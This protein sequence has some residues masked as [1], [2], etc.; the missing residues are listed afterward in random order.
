MATANTI[1]DFEYHFYA[2]SIGQWR[3]STDL[4]KL[5]K[6]MQADRLPY[7]LW[8]VPLAEDTPYEIQRYAPQV[9]GATFLGNYN[10]KGE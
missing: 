5:I 3:T 10:F 2:S 9:D 1:V 4:P 7:S 8:Y 6:Q